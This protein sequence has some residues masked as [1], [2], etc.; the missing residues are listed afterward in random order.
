[1]FDLVGKLHEEC[2]VR[3]PEDWDQENIQT[4]NN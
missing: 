2:G 3:K 4:K 1:M